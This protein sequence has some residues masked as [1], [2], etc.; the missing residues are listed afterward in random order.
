M[1]LP[2]SL[3][4]LFAQAVEYPISTSGFLATHCIFGPMCIESIL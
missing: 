3:H 1:P 4:A 2:A